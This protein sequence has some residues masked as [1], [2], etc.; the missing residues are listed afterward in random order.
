MQPDDRLMYASGMNDIDEWNNRMA[1][2]MMTLE[3]EQAAF[4]ETL[5][6][7]GGNNHGIE[8]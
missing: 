7:R 2:G 1:Q 8:D 5:P 3:E 4:G 6:E